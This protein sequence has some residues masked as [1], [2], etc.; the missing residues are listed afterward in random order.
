MP[1][2]ISWYAIELR[3]RLAPHLDT[4][5]V[6]SIVK[7]AEG[8]LRESAEHLKSSLDIPEESAILAA[9][10][11]FGS[12]EKVALTHLGE[13]AGRVLGLKPRTLVLLSAFVALAC[14]NF[15]WLSLW[16][17][18]DNF[19]ATWQ[20]GLAGI[21][22]GLALLGL[23]LGCRAARRSFRLP[24]LMGGVQFLVL[25][26]FFT[27][28]WSVTAPRSQNG[29][30]RPSVASASRNLP[31]Y[32][33]RLDRIADFVHEG[34]KQF[35][36]AKSA[37]DLPEVFRSV[38]AAERSLDLPAQY[39]F[40]SSGDGFVVPYSYI[41]SMPDG[42]TWAVIGEPSFKN[43]KATW[44]QAETKTLPQIERSK[45]ELR[46]LLTSVNEARQGRLFFF[47]GYVASNL[48][49]FTIVF[50]P[51]LIFLDWIVFTIVRTRR[52]WPSRRLA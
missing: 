37:K 22:G 36:S 10:D 50:M 15:H 8:H 41:L 28:F 31:K 46:A 44:A 19:G 5:K 21:L 3:S 35:A 40:S 2:Y 52:A 14:W 43:A 51:V 23:I 16:G 45:S 39:S 42:R 12:P 13:S 38:A 11:S 29:I 34:H 49:G 6:E 27:A 4:V 17:P 33:D 26:L 24:L 32:I 9:I 48:I 1:D 20:N 18:F 7:E 25:A 30:M 47:N